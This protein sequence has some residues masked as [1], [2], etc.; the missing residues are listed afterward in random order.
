[1]SSGEVCALG[2]CERGALMNEISRLEVQCGKAME[3][4]EQLSKLMAK[5]Q[6]LAYA[7]VKDWSVT[8]SRLKIGED[9]WWIR[10]NGMF[11]TG[12]AWKNSH[13]ESWRGSLMEGQA[14]MVAAVAAARMME[15]SVI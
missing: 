10:W 12:A 14:Q 1:M 4:A 2:T 9:R 6:S 3:K 8:L 5:A 7:T 11:W 15:R 13:H